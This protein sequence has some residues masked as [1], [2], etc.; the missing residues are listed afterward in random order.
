MDQERR[1]QIEQLFELALD[2]DAATRQAWLAGACADDPALRGEVASL[3][4]AHERAERDFDVD[5]MRRRAL[6]GVPLERIGPYRIAGELGR[7]GMGTVYLA[8]Q[9]DGEPGRPVAIK[10]TNALSGLPD[11]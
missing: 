2:R 3:L 11:S 9:A 7:G 10:L 8:E 5:A 1:S 4:T 6:G